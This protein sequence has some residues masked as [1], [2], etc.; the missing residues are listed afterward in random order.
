MDTGGD[1]MAIGWLLWIIVGIAAGFLAEKI[2]KSN[3]GLIMNLI[4]GLVGAVIGGF[5]FQNLLHLDLGPNWLN[6]LVFATIGAVIL[7]FVL[8]LVKRRT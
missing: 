1:N 4:T 5:L 2:M 7:L 6:A 8:R 3:Q